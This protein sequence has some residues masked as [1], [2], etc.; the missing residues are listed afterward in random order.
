MISLCKQRIEERR[1][2]FFKVR[3]LRRAD[4]RVGERNN[5]NVLLSTSFVQRKTETTLGIRHFLNAVDS[6][7]VDTTFQREKQAVRKKERKRPSERERDRE[8]QKKRET[9]TRAAVRARKKRESLNNDNSL[10]PPSVL[11]LARPLPC[12]LSVS[13]SLSSPPFAILFFCLSLLHIGRSY[14]ESR[15]WGSGV[16]VCCRGAG[17]REREVF[18]NKGGGGGVGGWMGESDLSVDGEGD[19]CF[20]RRAR[21]S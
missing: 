7:A 14:K 18:E 19:R 8:R 1:V 5:G 2:F 21:A 12:L 15:R 4:A 16:A 10:N 20:E 3:V 13:V 17:R 6:A 11:A 9:Q